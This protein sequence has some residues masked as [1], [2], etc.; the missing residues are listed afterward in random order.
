MLSDEVR[1]IERRRLERLLEAVHVDQHVAS[2]LPCPSRSPTSPHR[3]DRLDAPIAQARPR[4]AR[5]GSRRAAPASPARRSSRCALRPEPGLRAPA[6]HRL[7]GGCDEQRD[8]R[9]RR[10]VE[11]RASRAKARASAERK[12]AGGRR[13]PRSNARRDATVSYCGRCRI[14]QKDL[15]EY[16][17]HRRRS[18][19]SPELGWREKGGTSAIEVPVPSRFRDP[20]SPDET[21][22]PAREALRKL[23]AA[24]FSHGTNGVRS[25]WY[26]CLTSSTA[27]FSSVPFLGMAT[28]GGRL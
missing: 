13:I 16:G 25:C 12:H 9:E 8:H 27:N 10:C 7:A 5:T 14:E 19:R 18:R 28:Q 22:F 17:L 1:G 6:V 21:I 26:Q 2:P 20:G 4:R 11:A 24:T 23:T 15:W 3:L